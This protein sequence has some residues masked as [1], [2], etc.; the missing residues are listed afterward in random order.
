MRKSCV[1]FGIE[2]SFLIIA[3]VLS[4]GLSDQDSPKNFVAKA[5][6]SSSLFILINASRKAA[7]MLSGVL[8]GAIKNLSRSSELAHA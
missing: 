5:L 6:K 3:S 8:G 2:V 1:G 7:R 4:P